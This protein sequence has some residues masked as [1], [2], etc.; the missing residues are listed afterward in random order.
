MRSPYGPLANA[1]VTLLDAAGNVV[2]TATTGEDGVYAFA[3]LD[4]GDY[5]V[6]AT[7]SPPV[8]TTLAVRQDVEDHVIELAHSGE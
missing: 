6:I 3:D 8:A 1:R 5:T 2:S 7:G 4:S